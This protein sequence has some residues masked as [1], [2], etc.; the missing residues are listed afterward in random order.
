MM[1]EDEKLSLCPRY[2]HKGVKVVYI[3][4]LIRKSDWSIT[5]SIRK[6][7]WPTFSSYVKFARRHTERWDAATIT[8]D[9]NHYWC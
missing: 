8:E 2:E 1:D 9:F 5:K 7:N 6:S 4:K 3:I